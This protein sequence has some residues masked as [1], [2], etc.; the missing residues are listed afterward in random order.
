MRSSVLS[1]ASVR[2]SAIACFDGGAA[3]GAGV[4][5]R[6]AVMEGK[7][8]AANKFNDSAVPRTCQPSPRGRAIEKQLQGVPNFNP[9]SYLQNHAMN[10]VTRWQGDSPDHRVN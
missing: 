7:T 1:R 2:R 5:R 9:N 3:Y 10:R 4:V 8:R 6:D